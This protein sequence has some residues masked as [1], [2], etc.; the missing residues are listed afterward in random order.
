MKRI[1]LIFPFYLLI[2]YV[3]AE[4]CWAT[5]LGYDCCK[6]ETL[7]YYSDEFG[8]WSIENDFWCGIIK[9][10]SY[11]IVE[12][13]ISDDPRLEISKIK[14][15]KNFCWTEIS[16]FTR[17]C[18]DAE[19]QNGEVDI[20]QD[21]EAIFYEDSRTPICGV[22]GYNALWNDR[23]KFVY[24]KKEWDAFKTEWNE[25][26]K[27]DFQRLSVNVGKDETEL[28]FGWY[29]LSTSVPAI[30]F[31]TD[32]KLEHSQVYEGTVEFYRSIYGVRYFS[33]KVTVT[34]IKPNSIYYYKRKLNGAWED[35]IIEF[36]TYDKDNFKFI[37]IGD[38]QIGGS[39]ER[40]SVADLTRVLGRDDA[41]RNDAFNWNMTVYSSF[42][43]AGKPSIMLSVG[44]Q[45]ETECFDMTDDE[46]YS[47][48]T[49]Y[50]A[51]LLPKLM[52][53]IPL[54]PTV[55]NHEAV[56]DAFKHHFNTPNSYLTPVEKYRVSGY[57]YFFK[58][59]NV[60]VVVLETNYGVCDDFREVLRQAHM[61][62]PNTDWRI[63][64]FHHNIY[65]NGIFHSQDEQNLD[66]RKCLTKY[67]SYYKFDV[68]LN[69]HD[70]IY[71]TSHYVT[72]DD[73]SK[74]YTI[75]TIKPN[76]V[77]NS[78]KG[79]FYITANCSTGSKLY[80]SR[81][82]EYD[83]VS[84]SEQ[85]FLS[86]FGILDFTKKDGKVRLTISNYNVD[87]Q[88]KI[89]DNYIIEKPEKCFAT[90]QGYPCC[91]QSKDIFYVD[92]YPWGIENDDWCGVV[93]ADIPINNTPIVSNLKPIPKQDCWAYNLGYLCCAEPTFIYDSQYGVD[94]Y[95]RYCGLVDKSVVP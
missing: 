13:K 41:T 61:K 12:Q 43:M 77:Y 57:N 71:T 55:G 40:I 25:K 81:K 30:P 74:G 69:G 60:L 16:K 5:V 19:I 68:A 23:E 44:D 24:T 11:E 84:Y 1:N 29:S 59:N 6:Q 58:Y 78:P 14:V 17:C 20:Y 86:S 38:P 21:G 80:G 52:Q 4:N 42:E 47:Q 83:Y 75:E 39:K 56:S 8:D 88:D 22:R 32:K 95:G 35:E 27:D 28:N 85:N 45:I 82:E 53:T 51:F 94:R 62:H 49:Q 87:T 64:M 91:T 50:S 10:D 26:F 54:A 76:K 31:G 3:K 72:Y 33:N 48:E 93:E 15:P 7:V 36:K 70:H 63:A 79:T 89:D 2:S 92:D 34:N 65:G 73:N 67:L 46:L 90:S 9:K 66:L 18:S 37:L